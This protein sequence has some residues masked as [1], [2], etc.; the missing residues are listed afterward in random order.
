MS[1]NSDTNQDDIHD[2]LMVDVMLSELEVML[3]EVKR[4]LTTKVQENI[5]SIVDY[6]NIR[7]REN[8]I[9]FRISELI[10]YILLKYIL[11]IV[12]PALNQGHLIRRYNN[13]FSRRFINKTRL[14]TV[15]MAEYIELNIDNS[16]Y[17]AVA[18]LKIHNLNIKT[19]NN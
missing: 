8:S 15:S 6:A 2:S 1:K 13:I 12:I 5:N 14:N 7:R 16:S 19:K 17:G 9:F 11:F 4:S 18:I 10:A 3:M